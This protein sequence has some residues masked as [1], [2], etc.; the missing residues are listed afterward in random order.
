MDVTTP[1]ASTPTAT[2]CST[3]TWLAWPMGP[4][5]WPLTFTIGTRWGVEDGGSRVGGAETSC[6]HHRDRWVHA[7]RSRV[8]GH[9]PWRDRAAGCR[10]L[11]Q[12]SESQSRIA[13]ASPGTVLDMQTI[14]DASVLWKEAYGLWPNDLVTDEIGLAPLVANG[15]LSEATLPHNRYA[16]CMDCADYAI[17]GWDRGGGA[18]GLGD[19]TVRPSEANDLVV[20][21]EVPRLSDARTIAGQLPRG[22]VLELAQGGRSHPIL[23]GRSAR[24]SGRCRCG[25]LCPCSRRGSGRRVRCGPGFVQRARVVTFS[26]WG[27]IAGSEQLPACAPGQVSVNDDCQGPNDRHLTYGSAILFRERICAPGETPR[28]HNC[29]RGMRIV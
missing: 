4:A 24:L 26:G 19:Y 6:R 27:R 21:V 12:S 1:L 20:R 2:A 15:F 16:E 17:L 14:I 28:T 23:C 11:C 7:D 9:A 22:Q 10:V 18:D 13:G 25:R 29:R 8:G 5:I 3:S